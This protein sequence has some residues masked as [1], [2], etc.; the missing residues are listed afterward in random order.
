MEHKKVEQIL[1][2]V[3]KTAK[4][5][6]TISVEVERIYQHPFYKKIVRMKKKYLVHD[7]NGVAKPGDVVTIKLVRPISKLKRWCLQ[8]VVTAAPEIEVGK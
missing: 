1:T 7:E 6:K 4:A 3:V 8:Q 2:G 5:E